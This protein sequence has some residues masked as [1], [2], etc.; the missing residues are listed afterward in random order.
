MAFTLQIRQNL[1]CKIF[2]LLRSPGARASA[3]YCYALP[4][5]ACP[6]SFCRISAEAVL[7]AGFVQGFF[8]SATSQFVIA[9]SPALGG[10]LGATWQSLSY[11]GKLG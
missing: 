6:A 4:S 1:G 2:A 5:R 10:V 3:K 8:T 11:V 7:L 9:R